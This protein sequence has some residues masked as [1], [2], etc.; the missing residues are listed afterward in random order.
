MGGVVEPGKI[1]AL[2]TSTSI[3]P[4]SDRVASAARPRDACREPSRSAAMNSACP[5]AA[6]ICSTTSTPRWGLRPLT[7]TCAP[8]AANAV[9]IARPMLLVAPVTSAVLC[10]SRVLICGSL[11][12]HRRFYGVGSTNDGE[13]AYAVGLAARGADGQRMELCPAGVFED[14]RL[15]AGVDVTVPPLLQGEQDRLELGAGVRGQGLVRRGPPG[16]KG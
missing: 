2:L 1:P 13:V 11:S 6:W 15:G 9:A 4:P 16:G 14:D 7:M 12:S 10:S 3:R 5:P 8:S